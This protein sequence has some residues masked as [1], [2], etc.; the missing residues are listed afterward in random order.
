[1]IAE[2]QIEEEVL[3]VT[4]GVEGGIEGVGRKKES[5]G[6][7]GS[8]EEDKVGICNVGGRVGVCDL[9]KCQQLMRENADC[10]S[11]LS[12]LRISAMCTLHACTVE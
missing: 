9:I 10:W 1:M 12:S 2:G 8:R 3:S 4:C 7:G 11:G 5:G 6:E